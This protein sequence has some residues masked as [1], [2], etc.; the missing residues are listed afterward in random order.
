[1][2]AKRKTKLNKID[3]GFRKR[4][5]ELTSEAHPFN[6]ATTL[7]VLGD[8]YCPF[9]D[10]KGYKSALQVLNRLERDGYIKSSRLPVSGIATT[11]V[12]TWKVV[13]R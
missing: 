12:T 11:E 8:H 13:D 2:R 7:M 9:R 4:I 1:M 10:L 5:T 6:I 3:I